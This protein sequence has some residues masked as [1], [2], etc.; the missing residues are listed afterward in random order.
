[1]WSTGAERFTRHA[2][3]DTTMKFFLYS[4]YFPRNDKWVDVVTSAETLDEAVNKF[5]DW[6]W[7]HIDLGE[8][9]EPYTM[10]GVSLVS[11]QQVVN[12]VL[13]GVPTIG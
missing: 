2:F 12:L 5:A 9:W 8:L 3:E 10:G 6:R 4:E 1:M 11:L 7:E 13:S